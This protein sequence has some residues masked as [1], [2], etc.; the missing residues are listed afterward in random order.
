MI[1]HTNQLAQ[2]VYAQFQAQQQAQQ[3]AQLQGPPPPPQT[4]TGNKSR[5][6]GPSPGKYGDIIELLRGIKNGTLVAVPRLAVFE[7]LR[8]NIFFLDDVQTHVKYNIPNYGPP[9]GLDIPTKVWFQA[10]E[11]AKRALGQTRVTQSQI[12]EQLARDLADEYGV[13]GSYAS[14]HHDNHLE[15]AKD[16][17]TFSLEFKDP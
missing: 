4:G 8:Q 10:E 1:D 11:N 9:K 5:W 17:M 16:V 15:H 13:D 2:Q 6:S 12:L 7:F 3:Q 14:S